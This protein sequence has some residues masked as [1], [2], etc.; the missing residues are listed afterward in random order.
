MPPYVAGAK[1][2][3]QAM[4]TVLNDQRLFDQIVDL[5]RRNEQLLDENAQLRQELQQAQRKIS[6]LKYVLRRVI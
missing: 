4:N 3:K 5:R 2:P 1:A 6:Y